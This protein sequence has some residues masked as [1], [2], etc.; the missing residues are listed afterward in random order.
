MI[1]PSRSA[2][3][4]AMRAE[5]PMGRRITA[6]VVFAV[7]MALLMICVTSD[8]VSPPS[9]P[10]T[11]AT[12]MP[13][14]G[15]PALA[16]GPTKKL[17]VKLPALTPAGGVFWFTNGRA[18]PPM[19]TTPGA[20]GAGPNPLDVAAAKAA[21]SATS[22]ATPATPMPPT[23]LPLRNSGTPPGF[24]ELGSLSFTS[25]LPVAMPRPVAAP[26]IERE[27]GTDLPALK[28]DESVHPRFVFSIP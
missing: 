3:A 10:A 17:P 23:K 7:A 21:Y 6:R 20:A 9:G 19:N 15:G 27:G 12:S 13:S 11:G 2:T 14:G 1:V 8:A 4:I 25:A 16:D 18:T 26:L 22:G 28:F 5:E 24:T